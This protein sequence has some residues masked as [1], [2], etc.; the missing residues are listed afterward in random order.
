MLELRPNYECRHED[1]PPASPEAVI[2]TFEC[3]F[4]KPCAEK[5]LKEGG[6]KSG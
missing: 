3:T 1:L 5:M 2:C 4:C 6:C